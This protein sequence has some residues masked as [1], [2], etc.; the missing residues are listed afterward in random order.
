MEYNGK[1]LDLFDLIY[2]NPKQFD[3]IIRETIARYD[4]YNSDQ[5]VKKRRRKE[6]AEITA[7]QWEVVQASLAP[8]KATQFDQAV[9]KIRGEFFWANIQPSDP[10]SVV[11]W[12]DVF[13]PF[14]S[15]NR[16]KGR[17]TM[18]EVLLTTSDELKEAGFTPDFIDKIIT[19]I[20]EWAER[21]M[22]PDA[23]VA[24]EV[25]EIVEAEVEADD[26]SPTDDVL[27]F[28]FGR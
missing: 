6:L 23:S 3:R 13:D 17:A 9:A 10:T 2:D 19:V 24:K 12:Q 28:F 1:T 20:S 11:F 15:F 27:S 14:V 7:I 22:N 26:D 16:R 5:H 18:T 8:S 4:D 21:L 25:K